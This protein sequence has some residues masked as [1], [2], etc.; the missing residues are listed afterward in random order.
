MAEINSTG[1]SSDA[2]NA[3]S[4]ALDEFTLPPRAK[5]LKGCRFGRLVAI[6]PLPPLSTADGCRWRCICDCGNFCIIKARLLTYK[7]GTRSC[8]CIVAD[9]NRSKPKHRPSTNIK[10]GHSSRS[11]SPEYVCWSS[12]IQRCTNPKHASYKNYGE[13]GIHVCQRWLESFEAF[14]ADMGERPTARHSIDRIDNNL[15]YEP[16]NCRWA[17]LSE[18]ASNRRG[19][20]KLNVFGR[21][22]SVKEVAERY[23]I[24]E[25][26][27]YRWIKAG[28]N[29]DFAITSTE[30]MHPL[31]VA[32]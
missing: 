11:V 28:K 17:T 3:P 15:G 5:N 8:G 29:I 32:H 6:S 7:N 23:G 1:A 4:I 31:V 18:Q 26:T 19:S 21:P 12:M 16:A 14:L 30:A 25:R 9:L 24:P 13:R 27:L 10:H 22:A 2:S 20:I